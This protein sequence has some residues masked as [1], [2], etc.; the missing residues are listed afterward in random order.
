[1]NPDL[2][3]GFRVHYEA[4][5]NGRLVEKW[6]RSK[7]PRAHAQKCAEFKHGFVR[8]VRL[9]PFTREQ[10]IRVFGESSSQFTTAAK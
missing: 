1:M 4:R 7:S 5:V 10:W 6:F 2:P 8:V 3:Y 9:E